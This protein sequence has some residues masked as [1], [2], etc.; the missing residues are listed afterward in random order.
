MKKIF[1][2]I[3]LC[4]FSIF[5]IAQCTNNCVTRGALAG[6]IY[7]V[8][9]DGNNPD[10]YQPMANYPTAFLDVDASLTLQKKISLVSYLDYGDGITVLG[11]L[12]SGGYLLTNGIVG[13]GEAL[14]A[15]MEAWDIQPDYTGS[16]SY[17]DVDSNHQYY[18]YINE[19]EDLDLLDGLFGSNF[20]SYYGITSTELITIISRIQNTSYNPVSNSV[21]QDE[22]NYFTP[23]NYQPET[24]GFLRGLEQGVFSHYAKNSF[25]IPDRKLNLNFSHYYS[26]QLVELPQS[27]FPI[28]PLGRGW[29]HTYNSYITRVEDAVGNDD[30]Y[31]IKWAD[32]TIHI[33]N[34]NENEYITKGVYDELSEFDSGDNIEIT[35]KNQMHY[36]FERLDNSEEIF[37]LYRIEDS[38][39]NQINIG[40]ETSEVDN[41]FER[42]EWVE[43]PSG[44]RLEFDYFLNSDRIREVVD[45][46]GRDIQF[47]YNEGRLKRFYDAKG[48]ETKYFYVSNDEDAPDEHQ[49]RR[50]LLKKVRLPRGNIIEAE[51][52]EDENGK[53][54]QYA[55]NNNEPVLI[56][57]TFNYDNST[58]PSTALLT[59]PMPNS[60]GTQDYNYEFDVNG[61]VTQFQNDNQNINISYPDPTDI[62]ALF[63]SNIDINGLDINYNYDNNGN[64]TSVQ[65]ENNEDED[66]WYD[67]DNNLTQYRDE[68]GHSTYFNYDGNSNLTSIQDALGNS[69]YLNY[70][71]FG[72]VTSITNQEGITVNYTYENDGAVSTINAPENLTS[73]FGYDGI[74]RLLS[75]TIN[76][77]TSSFSYDPNDN[78]TSQTNIGGLTTTFNYDQNDNLITIT[79]ANGVNTSFDYNNE[80]QVTSEAFGSLVKQYEYNDDG[81]L[82][83]YIKPSGQEINY[84]Y[85]SDG[86]LNNAGTITNVDYYNDDYAEKEGLVESIASDDIRYNFIYDELNRLSQVEINNQPNQTVFYSYDNVGNIIRMHYPDSPFGFYVQYGYDAKNRLVS[87][88]NLKS[89]GSL[90]TVV[91]YTYF[92]DDRIQRIYYINEQVIEAYYVYDD[93]GRLTGIEHL[94]H[95]SQGGLDTLF[96]QEIAL[97]NKGNITSDNSTYLETIE[98]QEDQDFDLQAEAYA[99]N[100]TNHITQAGNESVSVSDDGNTTQKG[101]INY[102][103]NIDDQLTN[104][105]GNNGESNINFQLKYDAYG[106]RI[107]K[108]II[109]GT[110]VSETRRYIWDIINNNV[111]KEYDPNSSTQ[112]YYIYGATGLEC[113]VS[114]TT[115]NIISFYH[116][117][118]RGSIIFRSDT[119]G[120]VIANHFNKYDDFGNVVTPNN[121]NAEAFG[122]YG[123]LGKHGIV[124]DVTTYDGLYYIK[125]RY[126]DAKLGR[127]LTQDPIWSA[128]LYPYSSN[129]PISN[130]DRNGKNGENIIGLINLKTD[131]ILKYAG[132]SKNVKVGF[133]VFGFGVSSLIT[134]GDESLNGYQKRES[135]SLDAFLAAGSVA[136][137]FSAPQAYLFTSTA[138]DHYYGLRYGYNSH[139]YKSNLSLVGNAATSL[140]VFIGNS[141]YEYHLHQM[142]SFK[143][144]QELYKE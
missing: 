77:Q 136:V 40:Y 2:V 113:M 112:F 61:M 105:L 37:Y 53:L 94:R 70:D 59:V 111:I 71:S 22:D 122:S 54:I 130:I 25:V 73:S 88:Q 78:L 89:D 129:N 100:A 65:V 128:N 95:N 66:F 62:D 106:N 96:K 50:F 84:N 20:N 74:N 28:Q 116:G 51:Y 92:A 138:K 86:K 14:V 101:D 141:A 140:G 79:N 142:N 12:S 10:N 87:I 16:V 64:V 32:G 5:S 82:D 119:N 34:D 6:V 38:N 85:T 23:N 3:C 97:D 125:A 15:L 109:Q 33:Y 121:P 68:N 93:A 63:P 56:D 24:L 137:G 127:F 21:L 108:D 83:T 18:G 1:L 75:Q 118:L 45:P 91:Q 99:Y 31:Y 114:P 80:D 115:G 110:N 9:Y 44:K 76:G 35:T 27:Y 120:E 30:Y 43:A 17:N 58:T 69:I 72:Q 29:T 42:I 124:N 143:L 132:A 123:Y 55:L 117:D 39:G 144:R 48:Q 139:I 135:I 126:Y 41:D 102:Q 13:R 46:I 36:F 47:T 90:Q 19:A 133:G 26:T 57:V 104:V 134:L 131:V 67:N 8:V 81:T 60:G 49:Y 103:Y 11:H 7:E 4:L 98:N 52:D 107:E